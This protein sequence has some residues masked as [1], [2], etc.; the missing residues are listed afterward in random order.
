MGKGSFRCEGLERA[1]SA[2]FLALAGKDTTESDQVVVAERKEV[3]FSEE[4]ARAARGCGDRICLNQRIVRA[5]ADICVA[6]T[7]TTCSP[8]E[9]NPRLER[10][11]ESRQL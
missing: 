3:F 2:R 5:H 7:E 4:G 11:S 6:V 10:E 8:Q 1:E 9:N